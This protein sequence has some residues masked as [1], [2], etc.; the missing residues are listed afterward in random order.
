MDRPLIATA[1]LDKDYRTALEKAGAA[2]KE[3]TPTDSLPAALDGCQGVLLTGGVD[4]DPREYGEAESHPTVEIDAVRDRYELALTREALARDLPI[5][6]ICR[7]T[8]VLNTAAGGTL[9]Q[10]I[11]SALPASLDHQHERPKDALAHD[12]TVSRGTCLWTLLAPQLGGGD[13][14]AVNSRHHQSVKTAA[15]GF[16]VS[17]VSPDGIVEAIEKPAARF[18]VGVQ[19]HPENFHRGGEF[20]TLF[21]GL[22]AAARDYR[23]PTG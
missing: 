4:V 10:D 11:P 16:V 1:W 22:V 5:L 23:P 2:I 7:G 19:W 6:A 20:R 8:Q 13:A 3:L 17:A 21:D 18:C 12:V 15:P 14:V 9:V